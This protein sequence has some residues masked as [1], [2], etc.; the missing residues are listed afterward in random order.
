MPVK[1]IL[2]VL[3]Q[4][5][6]S[7]GRLAPISENQREWSSGSG[8]VDLWSECRLL[9][10]IVEPTVWF[11]SSIPVMWSGNDTGW[12]GFDMKNRWFEKLR[13]AELW[14]FDIGSYSLPSERE[15]M[16]PLKDENPRVPCR[17]IAQISPYWTQHNTGYIIC[18]H[19]IAVEIPPPMMRSEVQT[20]DLVIS[21]TAFSWRYIINRISRYIYRLQICSMHMLL[22][23]KTC[24]D[25]IVWYNKDKI[26]NGIAGSIISNQD[27][28]HETV[29]W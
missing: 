11:C 3:L 23:V 7:L 25:Q 22:A 9:L 18:A 13:R 24:P 14:D 1:S 15:E 28:A 19:R 17:T 4:R 8:L 21:E 29:N 20:L 2:P 26:V 5:T 16:E 6:D 12:M 27:R 10:E